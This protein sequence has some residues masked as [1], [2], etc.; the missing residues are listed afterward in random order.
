MR[1]PPPRETPPGSS[2]LRRSWPAIT[3]QPSISGSHRAPG[4]S[5]SVPAGRRG[6]PLQPRAHRT[7][8][9]RRKPRLHR[10]MVCAEILHDVGEVGPN[11]SDDQ[12]TW[13]RATTLSLLDA[14]PSSESIGSTG[15]GGTVRSRLCQRHLGPSHSETPFPTTGLGRLSPREGRA[16][17]SCDPA[18]GFFRSPFL[19]FPAR[20]GLSIT[21]GEKMVKCIG[22][23]A[24]LHRSCAESWRQLFLA[25]AVVGV[26]LSRTS[27][28]GD[29]VRSRPFDVVQPN[30]TCLR[31][32]VT[33]D[34]HYRWVH[35]EK[36]RV[37]LRDP[38]TGPP[39]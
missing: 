8:T 14:P 38:E 4:A 20:S 30:G 9:A 24:M 2:V 10:G 5:P 22:R 17:I 1:A 7:R 6:D 26:V 18:P 31:L 34:E 23:E 3:S 15:I 32:L 19:Y 21:I 37:I 33:G 16:S 39:H 36:G 13:Y 27:A 35:D 25:A 12:R 11:L 29:Y 28:V